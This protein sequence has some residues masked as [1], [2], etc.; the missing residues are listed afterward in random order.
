MN[1]LIERIQ[2]RAA[3][4][5]TR[6]GMDPITNVPSSHRHLQKLLGRPS[7]DS[8]FPFRSYSLTSICR[9]GTVDLALAS[10]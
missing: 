1:D 5:A 10:A 3:N 9:W 7:R 2:I 8:A 4:P 6:T